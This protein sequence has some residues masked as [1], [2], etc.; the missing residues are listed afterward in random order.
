M[1]VTTFVVP[2]VLSAKAVQE[3][4]SQLETAEWS[5]GK[6]TAGWHAKDVKQNQQLSSQ[7]ALTKQLEE[8]VRK[9]ALAHPLFKAAARPRKVHTV[10]FNR[11][12]K[13]MSYGRHTDDA[14]MNGGRSDLSFTL[15]LSEPE[16]YEGGELV[17]ERLD[18]ERAFKLSAGSMIVYPSSSLH[19]VDAVTKGVRWAV[20]G[21]LESWVRSGERRELLFELDTARRSLYQKYGKTDEF[22]LISKSLSNLLRQWTE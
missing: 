18:S 22:D 5:D 17:V 21:W 1:A 16:S 4:R 12:E 11:Y 8:R 13:G 19:R 2:G 9:A 7:Q 6:L 15:F 14:L 20:V 3:L 10:R